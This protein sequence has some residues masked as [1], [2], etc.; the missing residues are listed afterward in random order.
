MP[1]GLEKQL[2]PQEIADLLAFLALDKPPGD[3]AARK[4]KGGAEIIL[5]SCLC[6][7]SP[8]RA[9]RGLRGIR[10]LLEIIREIT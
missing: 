5:C 6:P 4:I 1:E 7:S 10:S 8:R 2:Q 9:F 3:P